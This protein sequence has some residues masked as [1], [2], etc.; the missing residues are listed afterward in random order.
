M[1]GR[2]L[3][4]LRDECEFWT[5]R[6]RCIRAVCNRRRERIAWDSSGRKFQHVKDRRRQIAQRDHAWDALAPRGA[7]G[8]EDNQ[9]N[10]QRGTIQAVGVL[11]DIVLAKLFAMIAN[12]YDNGVPQIATF[13]RK[14]EMLMKLS[15]L[16]PKSCPRT[17]H[18]ATCTHYQPLLPT[19]YA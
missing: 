12:D 8:Y 1:P 16:D 18:R 13:L 4:S 7:I 17:L 15:S 14:T 10:M 5:G 11:N 9:W 6:K 3:N 19:S 2:I